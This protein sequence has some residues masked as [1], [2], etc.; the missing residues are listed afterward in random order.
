[1][2][3]KY[4]TAGKFTWCDYRDCPNVGGAFPREFE[5]TYDGVQLD[6][7]DS[8]M[9]DYAKWRKLF[10]EQRAYVEACEEIEKALEQLRTELCAIS[11]SADAAYYGQEDE[12]GRAILRERPKVALDIIC[13]ALSKLKQAKGK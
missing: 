1:M 3:A 5:I 4:E 6:T 9:D 2:S 7:F 13:A 10:D 11:I 8:D 12:A